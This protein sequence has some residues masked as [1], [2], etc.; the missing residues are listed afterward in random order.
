MRHEKH[1]NEVGEAFIGYCYERQPDIEHHGLNGWVWFDKSK[2]VK[3]HG[4]DFRG[5]NICYA[6]AERGAA[7]HTDYMI[8]RVSKLATVS[9]P[10]KGDNH[11]QFTRHE[12]VKYYSYLARRSPYADVFADKR[13]GRMVD[14]E[15]AVI[16]ASAPGNLILAG[17]SAQRQ[18]WE[19]R[20]IPH[21]WLYLKKH[22]PKV[23]EDYLFCIAH[24]LKVRSDVEGDVFI[25]DT[26]QSNH[27]PL[28]GEA[29]TEDTMRN[30]LNHRPQHINGPLNVD[31]RMGGAQNMFGGKIWEDRNDAAF[32][33][34]LKRKLVAHK[35]NDDD[36]K[37]LFAWNRY[38]WKKEYGNKRESVFRC[39]DNLPVIE[40]LYYKHFGGNE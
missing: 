7:P 2:S 8:A 18:A 12:L 3:E 13:A 14:K 29:M 21:T 5:H 34:K 10:A 39:K 33:H 36:S 20:Q 1:V 11:A 9:C 15:F 22:L 26:R 25:V 38:F 35:G 24:M 16:D 40:A 6:G 27:V 4:R 28:N 30:F 17:L 23:N 37:F 19:Y 32:V 31:R